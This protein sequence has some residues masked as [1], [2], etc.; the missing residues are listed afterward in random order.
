MRKWHGNLRIRTKLFI[1]YFP[2]FILLLMLSFM[3]SYSLVKKSIE[4]NLSINMNA[5]L[6]S[7]HRMLSTTA[8]LAIRNHLKTLVEKHIWALSLHLDNAKKGYVTEAAAKKKALRTL[9]SEKI[10]PSGYLYAISSQG[11]VKAHPE[12]SLV[13]T[14]QSHQDVI[15]SQIRSPNGYLEYEWKNPGEIIPRQKALYMK[16]FKPW[17]LI[18]SA[19]SYKDEFSDLLPP[20]EIQRAV[21]A[22]RL[23]RSGYAFVI[24]RKGN[25]IIPPDFSNTPQLDKALMENAPT[26]TM[27]TKSTGFIIDIINARRVIHA[28]RQIP[29]FG[30]LIVS[31][32]YLDEIDSASREVKNVFV[33]T[34]LI[35]AILLSIIILWLSN[36]LD[37]PVQRIINTFEQGSAGNF[38]VRINENTDTCE[39]NT[40]A[41]YFNLLM[42]TVESYTRKLNAK[43]IELKASEERIKILAK[44]PDE[45]PNPVLRISTD[46]ILLYLN[47]AAKTIFSEWNCSVGIPLPPHLAQK[48]EQS[49][50]N[51]RY[52]ELEITINNRIF[53]FTASGVSDTESL[54]FYGR[55]ITEKKH[56]EDLLLLSESV[57]KNTIEGITVTNKKGEIERVNPAFEAITGYTPKEVIGKNPRILKSDRHSPEF[58]KGM[59]TS[60]EKNGQWN[61]EIWNR[62]KNGEAYPE[63]LSITV[64]KDNQGD[65]SGYIGVFHDMTEI[66]RS[67]EKL[68]FR[69]YHDS[70]T[71]LPN[72]LLFEDR[73]ERAI[74][75]AQ[76]NRLVL[77][78]LC[79]D[80]DNFKH[81]NESL[82]HHFG[83]LFL[84]EVA[85]RL[86]DFFEDKTTVSRFGGDQFNIILNSPGN[87]NDALNVAKKL[88]ALFE[89]GFLV[90][91]RE[92]YA[93]ISM[94]ISFFPTD[95]TTTSA[96]IK[97]AEI[98]MHKT[99]AAGKNNY[100]L[101]ET[102]MNK[103]VLKRIELESDLRH[104]LEK[105]EFT[106]FYQPKVTVATEKISGMEALIR[107]NNTEKGII[108]PADFIPLAEETGLIEQIGTWVLN[109]ACS[110]TRKWQKLGYDNLEIAVNLSAMQFRNRELAKTIRTALNRSG[111]EPRFLNLEITE[112]LVMNDVETA[113]NTMNRIA[114]MGVHFSIDDFGT[115]YSSLSYLKRF[116]VSIL[117]VDKSFV[118][119]IPMNKDDM[120]ISRTILSMAKSL[121]MRTVA[122]GVETEAQLSFMRTNHCD[123]I[124]GYYFSPPL[125]PD[126]FSALLQG[127]DKN[128]KYG[129]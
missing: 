90:Q 41:R 8:D 48:L 88:I 50:N 74:N 82:G 117:K 45:N 120:A 73:L 23:G 38:S 1:T 44:F 7:I 59:W 96:L 34:V 28:H 70:L 26:E 92:V 102:E 9:I 104:A 115:G 93:N 89:K 53:S 51:G 105:N 24:D 25:L 62:R 57:F 46:F 67:Q 22:I 81:I 84:Q 103:K 19:S 64:I 99:K 3:L 6:D 40:L 83:D 58:Y 123:E 30:W 116:P 68:K 129:F 17:D 65:I 56:Y 13:G 60:L 29:M 121:N 128:S 122:E 32:A 80:L 15:K 63:W 49:F 79:L 97:N 72:R 101:F 107:W 11:I 114:D 71:G 91:E 66:K 124:Q 16:T 35:S 47:K 110:Q 2:V 12:S 75:V 98:A 10:G 5:T 112:S 55:E 86:S 76:K 4:T 127:Q 85:K 36:K 39:L 54:Y 18:I 125:P 52:K 87:A 119:E 37:R 14:D 42:K 78:I 20:G 69:T 33:Q 94:G 106:L 43:I 109:E 108:S 113:I 111:L 61:G 100:S 21:S 118:C 95:G 77:A 126:E 31:S 27:L